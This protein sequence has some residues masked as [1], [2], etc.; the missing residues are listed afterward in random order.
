MSSIG[1]NGDV[2]R[3][4]SLLGHAQSSEHA[5]E[6]GVYAAEPFV[7]DE[8]DAIFAVAGEELE[9]EGFGCSAT[10]D[11]FIGALRATGSRSADSR[12]E[13][14]EARKITEETTMVLRS[15]RDQLSPTETSA[16]S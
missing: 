11:F 4:G 1:E 5:T 13:D 9:G 3:D 16:S 14:G 2:D 10:A 15:K 7:D 8:G 12:T 6:G